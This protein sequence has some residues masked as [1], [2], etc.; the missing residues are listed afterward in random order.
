V[1]RVCERKVRTGTLRSL[2]TRVLGDRLLELL[3]ERVRRPLCLLKADNELLVP[4]AV[5]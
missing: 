4:G 5:T 2:S 1:P 3:S